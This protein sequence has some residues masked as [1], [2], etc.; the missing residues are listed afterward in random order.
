MKIAINALSARVGGGQTYLVNLLAHLPADGSV[1]IIIFSDD[2]LLL[3]SHP[4]IKRIVPRWPTVNPLMRAVWEKVALP[5]LLLSEEVKVL[6]CPGGVVATRAPDGCKVVTMFRNMIPFDDKVRRAIPSGLQKLRNI[7]LKRV[8]LKSM[9]NADL[10]IFISSYARSV[11]E[12]FISPRN[13]VTI[14]HGIGDLFKTAQI[15]LPKPQIAPD[16]KYLL[17]V[18]R[19]DVYKHHIEVISAFAS[20]SPAVRS[21]LTLVLAGETNQAAFPSVIELIKELKVESSV[22][23]LG[24]V[25]YGELPALYR[26]AE[27]NIFMSSCENCPNILLEA[28]AAGRPVICS[29]TMPMPE[30]GGDAVTYCPPTEPLAIA[31]GLERLLEAPGLMVDLGAKA[32]SHSRQYSWRHT[33]ERTWKEISKLGLQ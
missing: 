9:R 5:R 33:A 25:P 20:L 13:A 21:G 2:T 18:S 17:Y 27:V 19:F 22:V 23:I 1:D 15:D 8:M 4:Y 26:N 11:I 14:P 30:F 6:F 12:K 10:T 31:S 24:G 16:G 7:V 29:N 28:M 3:P 32:A